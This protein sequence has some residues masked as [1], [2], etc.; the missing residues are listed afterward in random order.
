MDSCQYR[1]T[2]GHSVN[3]VEKYVLKSL[4]FLLDQIFIGYK[5]I[6]DDDRSNENIISVAKDSVESYPNRHIVHVREEDL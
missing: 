3:N 5:V 1:I 2:A 6:L 4:I